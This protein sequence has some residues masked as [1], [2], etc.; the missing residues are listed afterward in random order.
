[1]EFTARDK[2]RVLEWMAT[3]EKAVLEADLD[4]GTE[5]Y[6]MTLE[7]LGYIH[8]I[9]ALHLNDIRVLMSVLGIDEDE[10]EVREYP[11]DSGLQYRYRYSIQI[12]EFV[13]YSMTK[14]PWGE[15]K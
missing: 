13:Y 10:V 8:G 7:C 5:E 2:D 4:I 6:P 14:V 11:E 9:K 12:G 15:E 1:M 3:Q